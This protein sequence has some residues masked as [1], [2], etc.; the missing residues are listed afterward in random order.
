MTEPDWPVAAF[1]PVR[2]LRVVAASIPGMSFHETV[3]AASLD[4]VWAVAADLE[5]ELRRW[6]FAD[7]RSFEVT[8]A[9]DG[10]RLVAQARGYSGLRA[11]FDV[12]LQPGW[13]LMQSRFLL[14]GMAASEEDGATRFALLSGLRGPL[15][16][17]A[18]AIRPITSG[19]GRRALDRFTRR[20][21]QRAG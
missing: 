16:L 19:L 21:E 18:P 13:C 3:I 10:E 2:R 12:V 11:R 15:H 20:L 5:G 6:A 7:I 8:R 14:G 9:A 17:L 4:D 1:D